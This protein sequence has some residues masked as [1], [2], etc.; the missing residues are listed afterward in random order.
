MGREEEI[1][2]LSAGAKRAHDRLSEIGIGNG[3]GSGGVGS[4]NEA[5]RQKR[6]R[7]GEGVLESAVAGSSIAQMASSAMG[8]SSSSSLVRYN[9]FCRFLIRLKAVLVT[10]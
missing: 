2:T 8:G 6:K 5:G 9:Y 4:S 10:D 3:I 7:I 1:V